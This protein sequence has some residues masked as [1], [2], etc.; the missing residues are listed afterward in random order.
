[1]KRHSIFKKYSYLWITLIL[2]LGSI[3]GHWLF[4]WYS[5]Q[6]EAEEHGEE[7]VKTEYVVKTFAE[8]FENWQSE[9]LQ[10]LWQVGGLAI[11]FWA[12]SPQSKEG[13]E[14]KEEKID[15]ILT[16]LDPKGARETIKDINKKYPDR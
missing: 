10:L 1:M 8:T 13:D 3:V 6:N 16:L 9:F 15:H 2:F 14:R 7:P 12:G 5:F 11:F 4:S